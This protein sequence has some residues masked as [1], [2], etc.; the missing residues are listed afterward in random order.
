MAN[1][2][3]TK[4]DGIDAQTLV[5]SALL[6][7]WVDALFMS[8]FFSPSGQQGTFSE[9]A[10]MGVSALGV[11][12]CIV[13]YLKSSAVRA[14][15]AK[16]QAHL[17]SGIVGCLG[18][19]AFLAAGFGKSWPILLVGIALCAWCMS[20]AI[21]SWGTIYCA[22]GSKSAVR[23]VAGGFAFAFLFDI[24]SLIML[25]LAS[26]I[27]LSLAPLASSGILIAL[28]RQPH[29]HPLQPSFSEEAEKRKGKDVDIFGLSV[30]PTTICGVILVMIGFG[31]M[32]HFMSFSPMANAG[33]SGGVIV[34]L[35]RGLAAVALF[36]IA[37]VAP[38]RFQAACRTGLLVV[39]AGFSLMPFLADSPASWLCG[40]LVSAGYTVFDVFI[41]VVVAQASYTRKSDPLKTVLVVRQI[42]NGACI[43][44]G[45]AIG[46]LLSTF[47][48]SP[49]VPYAEAIF[50]G[51]LVTVAIVLLFESEEMW[52]LFGERPL[53]SASDAS[54][55]GDASIL[56][57][58]CERWGLTQRE[59]EILELLVKG[60]SQPWIAENLSI[61]ESTVNTHVRH[62]YRKSGVNSK[63][64]LL[65]RLGST[66]ASI[67]VLP[68]ETPSCKTG[69]TPIDLPAN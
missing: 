57:S 51:Y 31:Y 30:K 24:V 67:D 52:V 9:I 43:T 48:F 8:V 59:R 64:E 40:A 10:T 61:A 56:E 42:V 37:Q 13:L 50:A 34:Q 28:G 45:A 1:V 17:V 66:S 33:A 12:I 2:K 3:K 11:P 25:P 38:K 21:A 44:L 68:D 63:Q 4:L 47:P 46:A 39:V 20:F 41:W 29:S 62:I 23:Y 15:I 27:L 16:P 26:A 58:A 54:L 69:D 35:T 18:S 22:D 55:L 6:W 5:G 36:V 65:D 53:P 49:S 19:L 32:Q 7:A 14:L 60:R